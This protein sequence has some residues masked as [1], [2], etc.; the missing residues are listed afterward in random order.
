[1]AGTAGLALGSEL[2]VGRP[3]P[4]LVKPTVRPGTGIAAALYV[5]SLE[6]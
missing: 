5:G 3:V 2:V 1:M 6:G 4:G